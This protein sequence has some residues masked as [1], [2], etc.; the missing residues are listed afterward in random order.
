MCEAANITKFS[1][2]TLTLRRAGM[3][4][5]MYGSG[6]FEKDGHPC[7]AAKFMELLLGKPRMKSL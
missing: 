2:D 5:W 4:A 6:T 3:D 7:F 1:F